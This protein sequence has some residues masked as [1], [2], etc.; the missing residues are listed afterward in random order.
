[1]DDKPGWNEIS[2]LDVGK[3]DAGKQNQSKW[4]L[5]TCFQGVR[6]RLQKFSGSTFDQ[7]LQLDRNNGFIEVY[8]KY[9]GVSGI[10]EFSGITYSSDK[11]RA[12]VEICYYRSP[13]SSFGI[14]FLLDFK[15]GKWNIP[16][17]I[18]DWVL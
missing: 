16:D 4:G 18:I 2:R 14:F 17:K 7:F 11:S 15:Q 1:L 10:V 12:F 5:D 6:V 3:Q 13:N 8:K 9:P